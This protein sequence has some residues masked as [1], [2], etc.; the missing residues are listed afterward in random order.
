MT[1]L[2][3]NKVLRY[4]Y[5][6]V[7]EYLPKKWGVV[8]GVSVRTFRLFD[9]KDTQPYRKNGLYDAIREHVRP[10]DSV[11]DIATGRGISATIAGRS[12]KVVDSYEASYTMIQIARE[13]INHNKVSDNVYIHHELVG[14]KG[15]LFAGLHAKTKLPV[16]DL[17]N[18]T[19]WILD[20]DG[21]EIEIIDKMLQR[22][23]IPRV[24]IVESHPDHNA[25]PED[26]EFYML[27]IGYDISTR[28]YEPGY[29][30]NDKKIIIGE[31]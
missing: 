17:P 24:L 16:K 19:V 3:D 31:K 29:S 22:E 5:N 23:Q 28:K 6:Q 12:G 7:R 13:T 1:K 4:I 14:T 10:T 15:K 20:C 18:R 25:R 11:I 2:V 30:D 21:A 27:R 26:I 9:Q 8:N